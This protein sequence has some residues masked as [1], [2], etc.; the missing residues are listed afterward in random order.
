[1][2]Q[3]NADYTAGGA[4]NVGYID[5]KWGAT[6]MKM[7]L[8][9]NLADAVSGVCRDQFAG[10]WCEPDLMVG[11]GAFGFSTGPYVAR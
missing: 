4:L 9:H 10:L 8:K 2:L 5:N 7:D 3:A 1:M 6:G 11:L